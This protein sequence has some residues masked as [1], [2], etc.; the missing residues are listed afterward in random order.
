MSLDLRLAPLV[1][2]SFADFVPRPQTS[3][4]WWLGENSKSSFHFGLKRPRVLHRH[5]E[6]QNITH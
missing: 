2:P 1:R 3:H 5:I 4:R 6:Y